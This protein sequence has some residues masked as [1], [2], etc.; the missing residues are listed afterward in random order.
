MAKLEAIYQVDLSELK[1]KVEKL[2]EDFNKILITI[3]EIQ[4]IRIEFKPIKE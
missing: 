1:E 2:Q 4:N 3:D